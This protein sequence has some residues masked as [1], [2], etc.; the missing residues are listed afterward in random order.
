[1]R[2]QNP[3]HH[4]LINTGA[5]REINLLGDTRT[6]PRRLALFYLDDSTNDLFVRTLRSRFEFSFGREQQAIFSTDQCPME[7]QECR[8]FQNDGDSSQTGRVDEQRA[9]SGDNAIPAAQIGCAASSS[10]QNQELMLQ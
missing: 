2:C 6:A 10:V 3:P 5:E 8:G 1:M 9:K 7:I 4:I